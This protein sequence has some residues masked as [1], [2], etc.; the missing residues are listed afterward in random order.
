MSNSTPYDQQLVD[1][2]TCNPNGEGHI[3]FPRFDYEGVN[4]KST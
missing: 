1:I 3:L 4:I 2:A